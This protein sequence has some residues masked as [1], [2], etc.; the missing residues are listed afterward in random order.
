MHAY[1]PDHYQQLGVARDADA[2]AIRTA[3][4]TLAKQLHPDLSNPADP[5]S[6]MPF[7]RLQEAYD[8]LRDPLQRGQYDRELA[9]QAE[10]AAAA[11]GALRASLLPVIVTPA[12]R[13]PPPGPAFYLFVSTIS[14]AAFATVVVGVWHFCRLTHPSPVLAQN[15]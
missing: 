6:K 1:R 9:R 7:L 14:L 2:E 5:E 3:Y 13:P 8:V 4:R 15:A 12:P 10:M 11:R